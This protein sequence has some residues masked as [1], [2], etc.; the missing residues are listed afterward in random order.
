[1]SSLSVYD[2]NLLMFYRFDSP[3]GG[4]IQNRAYYRPRTQPDGSDL[5]T[6]LAWYDNHIA[7]SPGIPGYHAWKLVDLTELHAS[8]LGELYLPGQWGSPSGNAF[9]D[10]GH[11]LAISG[12][13]YDHTMTT[14]ISHLHKL[15]LEDDSDANLDG[16][17]IAQAMASGDVTFGGWVR[18]FT[19]KP[20]TYMSMIGFTQ[21]NTGFSSPWLFLEQNN[22]GDRDFE[23]NLVN[24]GTLTTGAGKPSGSTGG[25][26]G[27]MNVYNP[28]WGGWNHVAFSLKYGGDGGG[29][30]ARSYL[31]G[32]Q[33]ETSNNANW[34]AK[35]FVARFFYVGGLNSTTNSVGQ[36]CTAWKDFF[37]FDR[38][39]SSGEIYHVFNNSISETPILTSQDN[40]LLLWYRF[41]EHSGVPVRSWAANTPNQDLSGGSL[42]PYL[43]WHDYPPDPIYGLFRVEADLP[44][45]SGAWFP[46]QWNAQYPDQVRVCAS[47]NTTN[48]FHGIRGTNIDHS[49]ISHAISSGSFTMSMWVNPRYYSSYRV[50]FVW[51]RGDEDTVSIGLNCT[52]AS[53]VRI[54][55]NDG[56]GSDHSLYSTSNPPSGYFWNHV[57]VVHPSG[58]FD[59]S[60]DTARLYVNGSLAGSTTDPDFNSLAVPY[61]VSFFNYHDEWSDSQFLGGIKDFTLWKRTLEPHEIRSLFGRGIDLISS[62]ASGTI[63]GHTL[64]RTRT[65]GVFGG[66]IDAWAYQASGVFGGHTLGR[67][68]G[69]GVHGGYVFCGNRVSGVHGGFIY[70]SGIGSGVHGGYCFGILKASGAI[71]G[72]TFSVVKTSGACGGFVHCGLQGSGVFDSSMRVRAITFSDVDALVEVKNT[73][74]KDFDAEIEVYKNERPPFVAIEYPPPEIVSGIPPSSV[75]FVGSGVAVDGKQIDSAKYLF[76]DLTSH[77]NGIPSGS[78]QYVSTYTYAN[79][80]LY[81][82]TLRVVDNNGLVGSDSVIV[83]LASGVPL[84]DVELTASPRSGNAPLSVDFDYSVTSVPNGVTVTSAILYFGNGQSTVNPDTTYVYREP[85]VYTPILCILD[86][87]GIIT[88]D[89]LTIGVNN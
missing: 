80:G 6:D 12:L 46:S 26:P 76:G 73:I 84:P 51:S 38:V 72:R 61:L 28:P 20:L 57:C 75:W 63:G 9:T 55:Y 43:Y 52:S 5:N 16:T 23:L 56:T 36:G 31:N 18:S 35:R 41:V 19:Y 2:S 78:D 64:G 3:S 68:R 62:K 10:N 85:G 17:S 88:C 71:G 81:I 45:A 25:L 1:M 89:S 79:S 7:A 86:S 48:P 13:L 4:A 15:R 39:L 8:G 54:R 27:D 29:I 74:N 69:S 24:A 14:S 42:D 44:E 32:H 53:Q 82:A 47:G 83:D 40:D 11:H 37:L 87:R 22:T 67:W 59:G 21:V 66:Y 70:C 30:Y 58:G 34:D 33:V 65:S 49:D 77:A 60:S 50:P